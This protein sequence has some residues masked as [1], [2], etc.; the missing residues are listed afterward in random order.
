PSFLLSSLLSPLLSSPLLSSP[1]SLLPSSVLPLTSSGEFWIPSWDPHPH[2]SQHCFFCCRVDQS[3]GRI[4]YPS[5]LP[6]SITSRKS[7]SQ[8][9]SPHSFHWLKS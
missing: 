8:G 1:L 4:S 2:N 5:S 9:R 3:R 7:G 6:S